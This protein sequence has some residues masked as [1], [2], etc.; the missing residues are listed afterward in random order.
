MPLLLKQVNRAQFKMYLEQAYIKFL[1]H[2]EPELRAS[3]C[4]CLEAICQLMEPSEIIRLLVPAIQKLAT[5]A[6]PF[7]RG[8][9]LFLT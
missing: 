6:K 2:D 3:A 7:V 1:N 4:T 9:S 8:T 5:D